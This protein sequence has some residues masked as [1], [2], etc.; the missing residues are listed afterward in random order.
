MV[1]FETGDKEWAGLSVINR[2]NDSG[3]KVLV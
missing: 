3:G 1:L 2:E